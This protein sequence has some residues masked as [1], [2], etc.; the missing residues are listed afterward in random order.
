MGHCFPES[1]A[2]Y[3]GIIVGIIPFFDVVDCGEDAAITY[4]V[5][6]RIYIGFQFGVARHNAIYGSFA[7]LPLF[8]IWVYLLEP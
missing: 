8:M 2:K 4:M 7:A 6:Q 3:F 1:G 5:L